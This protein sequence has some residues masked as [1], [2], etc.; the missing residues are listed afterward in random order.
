MK[1]TEDSVVLTGNIWND[2][3]LLKTWVT[4]HESEVILKHSDG[5][6]DKKHMITS[7]YP[8]KKTSWQST[9]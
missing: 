4:I 3:K 5:I 1:R 7:K 6:K 9:A 8:E 2:Q